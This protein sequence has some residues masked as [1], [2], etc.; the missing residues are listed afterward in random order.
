MGYHFHCSLEAFADSDD[1]AFDSFVGCES[2]VGSSVSFGSYYFDYS[3]VDCDLAYHLLCSAVAM[4]LVLEMALVHTMHVVAAVCLQHDEAF[5]CCY[6]ILPPLKSGGFLMVSP[7][8]IVF[9]IFPSA[10]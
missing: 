7:S 2:F 1:S 8:S 4:Y 3:F 9:D 6:L 10:Q 5:L